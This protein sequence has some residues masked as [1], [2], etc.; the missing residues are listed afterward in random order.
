MY[1]YTVSVTNILQ[2]IEMGIKRELE[3]QPFSLC[4]LSYES[5][6]MLPPSLHR[7]HRHCIQYMKYYINVLL[8]LYIHLY[9][10]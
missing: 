8:Q 7:S 5:C 1:K 2:L 9:V 6:A 3:M 4:L 10:I